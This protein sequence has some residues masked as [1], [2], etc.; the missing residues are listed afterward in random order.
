MRDFFIIFLVIVL[1]S[2]KTNSLKQ[3]IS[4]ADNPV[5][6]HRGA[7]K[8]NNLPQNSIASLKQAIALKCTGSEFDVRM[9]S[10]NILIVTHDAD[11]MGLVVEESTYSELSKYKLSNGES[12][13]TLKQYL[14]AGME[15][16]NSTG[17]VCE[18]KPSKNEGQNTILA[19]SVIKLVNEVKAQAFILS[20]IS[21]NYGILK[22]IKE[23]DPN[24][25]TQYLDG[26]KNPEQL[27]KDGISG[28][29][30]WHGVYKKNPEWIKS[31]KEKGLVLNAWTAN[32]AEDIDWLL[33]NEFDFITTDEPQ[34]IFERIKE[35]PLQKGYKLVWSD[36]FNYTGK[37]D[38]SK[39]ANNYGFISN[40]EKQYFTDSLKN[41]RVEN[42]FLIIEA[43][44]EKIA[45]K[46]YKS[47]AFKNKSWLQ[48]I[49]EIDT[50]QYTSARL[51]T[52]GLASWKYGRIEVKA[53]LPNGIGLWPAIWMLGENRKQVGWPECG[54]IDIM[55]H[56]GFESD[57]IFGTIH[58]K[59]YNHTKGTQKSKKVFIEKPYDK[60]HV[61]AI[62]WTTEK[63]DF[64]LDGV[65]YYQ[66]ANEN[67]ST[68]EWPFN[69]PFYLI[70][71]VSVGGTLGGQKGIDD[72]IF[73]QQMLIDYVRVFQKL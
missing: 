38:S 34:L 48:Y 17:L 29:D 39:W 3:G 26:S 69:Q 47:I 41:V 2:C 60:F 58:T 10:D 32:T 65:V 59:A 46:D 49:P 15:N 73:P 31:A 27:K 28:L 42:G 67:K 63:L 6:A 9:T 19:E 7:W 54:E 68:A 36:E 64:I 57:T 70:M 1:A 50:A 16:N 12:L 43:H 11:Y 52:T 8:S 24:A 5:V 20:Y 56:I 13:P 30:Y 22:K 37:P 18:I 53:K 23:A 25:K 55:E 40:E 44:K 33:V 45:N 51:N 66:I 35:K 62:D 21:F 71:N 72:S 14:I 61:Y 4:F